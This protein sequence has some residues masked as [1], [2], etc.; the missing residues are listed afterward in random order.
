[1]H[2][3]LWFCSAAAKQQHSQFTYAG[4][5]SGG[6]GSPNADLGGESGE[7]VKIVKQ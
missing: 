4:L 3:D 1:L 7:T 6:G 5:T 2:R